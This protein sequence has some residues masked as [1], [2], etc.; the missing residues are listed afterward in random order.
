MKLAYKGS[1]S[2]C[3]EPVVGLKKEEER[4]RKAKNGQ[5]EWQRLNIC[6]GEQ[7]VGKGETPDWVKNKGGGGCDSN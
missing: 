7:K 1:E 5:L 2:D 6:E 4:K 3:Q